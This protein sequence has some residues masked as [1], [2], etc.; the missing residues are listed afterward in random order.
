[1][2]NLSTSLTS[3]GR[4]FICGGIIHEPFVDNKGIVESE[5]GHAH[6]ECLRKAKAQ[7]KNNFTL[8]G[9]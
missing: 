6:K 8:T 1:V 7:E 9:A 3:L 4:C 2:I 5:E